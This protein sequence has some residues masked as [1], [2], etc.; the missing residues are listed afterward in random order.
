MNIKK[1]FY[2]IINSNLLILSLSTSINKKIKELIFLQTQ[3]I[4]DIDNII[5][6]YKNNK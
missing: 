3:V 6:S 4:N 5:L 1:D 2:G